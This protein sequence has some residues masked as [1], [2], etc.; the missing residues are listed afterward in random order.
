MASQRVGAARWPIDRSLF[1]RL[2]CRIGAVVC[3]LFVAC[4]FPRDADSARGRAP[5]DLACTD[6]RIQLHQVATLSDVD[7]QIVRDGM[8]VVEWGDRYLIGGVGD[9]ESQVALVDTAGTVER[10]IG[11]VGQGPGQFMGVKS[12]A[13]DF[14][15]GRVVVLGRRLTVLD[16]TFAEI[17]TVRETDY[18][19]AFRI[20]R[21]QDG[22]AV[23]SYAGGRAPIL[24]LDN[25]LAIRATIGAV[26]RD[27]DSNQYVL[28]AAVRGGL[29]AARAAYVYEL[30]RY[31]STG[32]EMAV[33]TPQRGWFLPWSTGPASAAQD[34]RQTPLRPRV[35]GLHEL[36]GDKLAVL[37]ITA[38]Q[39][40]S[41]RK[42]RPTGPE[43]TAPL[44]P[45]EY[46]RY[47]D[48]VI[49][50]IDATT[51]ELIA[52]RRLDD[53]YAGITPQ[54]R[55]WRVDYQADTARVHIIQLT[56]PEL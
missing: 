34:I 56:V 25:Q 42:S 35:A 38:D 19:R 47:V 9:E 12:L 26:A 16:S 2:V 1:R 50:V 23:N 44:S 32:R 39:A 46:S 11:A 43:E 30:H 36:P 10:M 45:E 20:A 6:C 27:L 29:W 37:V 53:V 31:D 33:L 41:A 7:G 18:L 5:A 17:A 21:L 49:E 51:G 28:A 15:G 14:A 40:V 54:G 22:F 3:S 13:A 8:R 48:S 24:V 52:S 4:G 55:I